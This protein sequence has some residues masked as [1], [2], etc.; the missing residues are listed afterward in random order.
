MRKLLRKIIAFLWV[1]MLLFASVASAEEPSPISY[2]SM[3]EFVRQC[4][5][6]A[7]QEGNT[8]LLPTMNSGGISWEPKGNLAPP[9]DWIYEGVCKDGTKV[10]MA[11]SPND[12]VY[13]I[14]IYD[15]NPSSRRVFRYATTILHDLPVDESKIARFFA[16]A[17]QYKRGGYL[18]YQSDYYPE[19]HGVAGLYRLADGKESFFLIGTTVP[20]WYKPLLWS[21]ISGSY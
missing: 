16:D 6:K 11:I 4:N 3:D 1:S 13:S 21:E 10:Y 19:H 17:E 18:S 12:V 15:S 2:L 8:F 14:V 5:R 7:M 20:E 9:C